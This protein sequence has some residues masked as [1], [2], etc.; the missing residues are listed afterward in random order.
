MAI[1]QITITLADL[2]SVI[3]QFGIYLKMIHCKKQSFFRLIF[4]LLV[5]V[6]LFPSVSLS[7][8][9]MSFIPP[10]VFYFS[11]ESET[12]SHSHRFKTGL[13]RESILSLE[14]EKADLESSTVTGDISY[15]ESIQ[16]FQL[17]YGLN[18]A[19][20]FGITIPMIKKERISNLDVVDSTANTFVSSNS[21]GSSEGMGD[22]ELWSIWR[23]YYTDEF[24]FQLGLILEGSN[25]AYSYNDLDSLSLGDGTENISG[26]LRWYI[27]SKTS[28]LHGIIEANG[29]L[30]NE[31]TISDSNNDEVAL[32]RG[33]KSEISIS[34]AGNID[35][36]Q[37]GGGILLDSKAS[38]R[39][40]DSSLEDGYMGYL[41]KSYI[42]YG[43]LMLLESGKPDHL[44]EV[45]LDLETVIFGDNIPIETKIGVK[46]SYFF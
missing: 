45:Q 11:L 10:N 26:F 37:I 28:T 13:D 16:K 14:L 25:G 40:G 46:G 30:S 34:L 41:I 32:A 6:W 7:A 43:N 3:T 31:T 12:V 15:V 17:K 23:L 5:V 22:F 19:F 44:W 4:L 9:T 36:I 21:S 8:Q 29:K 33:N 20:N 18:Q 35:R 39:I 42:N 24:D 2:F 38:T 1:Q 27:Y